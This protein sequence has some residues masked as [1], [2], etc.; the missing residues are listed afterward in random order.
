MFLFGIL[1]LLVKFDDCNLN[2]VNL[3]VPTIPAERKI[4]FQSVPSFFLPNSWLLI[5][6]GG[7]GEDMNCFDSALDKLGR[8]VS[9]D[10]GLSQ[11]KSCCVIRRLSDAE[12]ESCEGLLSLNEASEVLRLS[13][14][15]KTPGSD[16]LT[17][18]FYSA[19]WSLLGILLVHMFNESL[20]HRKLCDSKKSSVMRLVH[21]KDD[22]RNL[23][24]WRPISLLN[25]DYKICSKTYPSV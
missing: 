23:K 19:F 21:K 11:L 10:S 8:S 25:V 13:N 17:V 9:L 5:G 24:N 6:R 7:G 14:R 4:F 15:N 12:R 1:S 16:G 3:N 18:E 2:L 22:R 20:A